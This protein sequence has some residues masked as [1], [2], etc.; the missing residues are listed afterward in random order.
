M[1]KEDG[2]DRED[3]VRVLEIA[4][5]L[6]GASTADR[7]VMLGQLRAIYARNIKAIKRAAAAR[8]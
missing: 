1:V 7:K 6:D 3:A 2:F 5:G 8:R 4:K